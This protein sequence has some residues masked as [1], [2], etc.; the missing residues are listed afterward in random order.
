[1]SR[2][3]VVEFVLK[4]KI[5]KI[6]LIKQQG[7]VLDQRKYILAMQRYENKIILNNPPKISE[8]SSKTRYVV[9]ILVLCERNEQY[10]LDLVIVN[11][12]K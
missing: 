10:K 12:A 9:G 4:Q 2:H 7:Q 11:K 5:L 1:M 3:G 8:S 6:C